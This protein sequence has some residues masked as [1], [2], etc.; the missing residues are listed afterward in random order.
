MKTSRRLLII[1]ATAII[2]L[3]CQ[4]SCVVGMRAERGEISAFGNLLEQH[5]DTGAVPAIRERT[6]FRPIRNLLARLFGG[7]PKPDPVGFT[8]PYVPPFNPIDPNK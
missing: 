8:K 4:S 2:I 1:L 5:R 3:L 7:R 6:R